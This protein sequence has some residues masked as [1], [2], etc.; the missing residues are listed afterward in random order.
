MIRAIKDTV[1]VV[2]SLPSLLGELA[3]Y[4]EVSPSPQHLRMEM[5]ATK[6]NARAVGDAL[7]RAV[8]E[9]DRLRTKLGE[10]PPASEARTYGR[11]LATLEGVLHE[12]GKGIANG[13]EDE[14]G[15][16]HKTV[17]DLASHLKDALEE[18]KARQAE[19]AAAERAQE[20]T[21]R[22]NRDAAQTLRD[23]IGLSAHGPTIVCEFATAAVEKYKELEARLENVAPATE[24][25]GGCARCLHREDQHPLDGCAIFWPK[26]APQPAEQ[27]S[28]EGR[29]G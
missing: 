2:L 18:N 20:H 28:E 9:R 11:F 6:V 5:E 26:P 15:W 8:Q 23:G 25:G 1:H 4:R 13:F 12:T 14:C 10:T 17:N 3:E 7:A 29:H 24:Q 19:L 22:L 21:R 16:S 27:L